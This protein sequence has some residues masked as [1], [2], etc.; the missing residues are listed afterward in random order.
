MV[1]ENHLVI[2]TEE[3]KKKTRQMFEIDD[4]DRIRKSVEILADWCRK[5]EH[6]VQK[7]LNKYV[8]ERLFVLSKGSMEETKRRLDRM[9]TTRGMI[10]EITLKR[11]VEEFRHLYERVHYVPLPKMNPA[12]Q[13]RV[14][15]TQFLT[16]QLEEFNILTYFRL[17]LMITEYRYNFD[18]ALNER[19]V[20]DLKNISLNLLSKLNPIV[21]K[22]SEI[23][24][25]EGFGIKIKGIHLVNAPPFVDKVVFILKQALKDKV[26]QRLH[27]HNSYQ[28]LHKHISKEILPVD[29]DGEEQA[30]AKLFAR[31]MD[32]L[33][34][35]EMTEFNINADRL[36]TDESKRSSD[37]FNEEYM[38][39]PGSFRK[40]NVD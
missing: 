21:V 9:L 15:I 27:V 20:I 28:D 37:K 6:F 16:N 19:Y 5:Q 40:L 30:M 18:Y 26:A 22:K 14:M 10:Y 25:T 24:C 23:L 31:W 4:E 11:S 35:P 39:M 32:E 33:S 17:A 12:D 1:L 38:G 13:T 36:I 29:Y 3:N 2:S 7:D 34:S 8:I